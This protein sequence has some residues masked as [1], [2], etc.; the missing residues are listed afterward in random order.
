MKIN[1]D[2]SSDLHL[3]HYIH[4]PVGLSQFM[5]IFPGGD[6]LLIAGDISTRHAGGIK[7]AKVFFD[8]MSQRY[9]YVV[10][11]RGNHDF[12]EA[13]RKPPFANSHYCPEY[14]NVILLNRKTIELLD[15]K[16]SGC[17]AWY[18]TGSPMTDIWQIQNAVEYSQAQKYWDMEFLKSIEDT[19]ILMTHTPLTFQMID[20]KF[21]GDPFNKYYFHDAEDLIVKGSPQLYLSGHTHS[22]IEYYVTSPRAE[23]ST[24]CVSHAA[25]YKG[26]IPPRYTPKRF[27]FK[28]KTLQL[29]LS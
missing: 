7:K 12:Y 2:F 9:Q 24:F 28:D 23:D 11:V 27:V 22:R 8:E 5:S 3:D 14:N 17:F 10:Y 16:I 1:I 6:L 15:L 20:P 19:D 29:S 26:E 4:D 18:E 25:G 13:K 21:H